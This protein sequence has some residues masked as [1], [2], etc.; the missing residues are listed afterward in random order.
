MAPGGKVGQGKGVGAAD[1]EVR[2]DERRE[3]GHVLVL[4]RDP[5]AAR[6]GDYLVERA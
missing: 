6:V 3:P 1:A 5:D 2:V 4:D